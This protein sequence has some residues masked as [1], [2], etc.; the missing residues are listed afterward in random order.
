MTKPEQIL[1]DLIKNVKSI[2]VANAEAAL[3]AC[4][5]AE[6][7]FSGQGETN[8]VQKPSPA[9]KVSRTGKAGEDEPKSAAGVGETDTGK[10]ETGPIEYP[11]LHRRPPRLRRSFVVLVL[12]NKGCGG[13][14]G[15]AALRPVC[16]HAR[17]SG[18]AL[19][20]RVHHARIS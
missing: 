13:S 10:R 16:A 20:A 9:K 12:L 3:L 1:K 11:R 6:V 15:R 4:Q 18:A 17:Q 5:E 2:D 19:H 7:Y 14:T 8:A